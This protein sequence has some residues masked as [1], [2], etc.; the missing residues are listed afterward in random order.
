MHIRAGKAL[1]VRATEIRV[2]FKRPPKLAFSV[3]RRHDPNELI[4]RIDP[5]PG[6]RPGDPG[7]GAGRQPTT[8][9]VDLSLIFS[10]ELGEAPEPYERLLSDAHARRLQPL[11]PGGRRRGDLAHRPAAAR[12]AASRWSP[13]HPGRGVLRGADKLLS[14]YPGWREPWLRATG[15]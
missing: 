5:S 12:R 7:E 9:T 11:R 2:I 8:R 3:A 14:G 6:D 10:E 4:L 13:T 1:P 15:H